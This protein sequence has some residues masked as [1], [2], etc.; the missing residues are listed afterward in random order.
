MTN[1]SQSASRDQSGC[2]IRQSHRPGR[3][4]PRLVTHGASRSNVQASPAPRL[5]RKRSCRR[6][7]RFCQNSTATGGGGSRPTRAEAAGR[8]RRPPPPPRKP[9]RALAVGHDL[10]LPRRPGAEPAAQRARPEVGFRLLARQRLDRPRHRH[11][12]PRLERPV[13]DERRVRVLGQL[14]RLAALR[15]R[16]E[17][18]AVLV[19]RLRG[20]RSAPTADPAAS[21]VASVIASGISTPPARASSSQ[22]A[23]C[24]SGSGGGRRRPSVLQLHEQRPRPRP[25]R[26]PPRERASRP[27]RTGRRAASPSSSPRVRRAAGEARRGRPRPRGRGR[28]LPA[29]APRARSSRGRRPRGAR[30]PRPSGRGRARAPRSAAVRRQ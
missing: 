20:G 29:S 18:E 10:A 27:P 6:F 9:A 19:R 3:H 25:G 12:P 8:P 21:A 14:A 5:Y 16:E 15:V 11:L 2:W 26:P 30:R 28:R 4:V 17:A 23:N 24:A 22:R 7:G 1:C 13:E